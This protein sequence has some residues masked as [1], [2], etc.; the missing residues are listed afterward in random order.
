ME[1]MSSSMPAVS[2]RQPKTTSYMPSNIPTNFQGDMFNMFSPLTLP[3]TNYQS[4]LQD[5]NNNISDGIITSNP[6]PHSSNPLPHSICNSTHNVTSTAV[7]SSSVVNLSDSKCCLPITNFQLPTGGFY[8]M[9]GIQQPYDNKMLLS[10]TMSPTTPTNRFSPYTTASMMN[11]L[12][13]IT[14]LNGNHSFG[15]PL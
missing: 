12:S 14:D 15:G 13:G 11:R 1:K 2:T 9:S 10:S 8:D 5:G 4:L 3:S 7:V 6:L